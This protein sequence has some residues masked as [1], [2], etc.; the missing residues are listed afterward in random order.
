VNAH[1]QTIGL[2]MIVKNEA[3]VIRRCID[4]LRG[5]IDR[6]VIAD[7]GSTDGTQEI[8]REALA[9]IPGSLIE[10]PW[11]DFSHNR[12]EVLEH[13]R[14]EH[15]TDYTLLMDADDTLVVGDDFAGRRLEADAYDI[16]LLMGATAYHRQVLV[17]SALP[18]RYRG[19]LH[20][21]IHCPDAR[22]RATLPGES[23]RVRVMHEGARSR[24][25]M[26]YRRDALVLERALIDEPDNARHVFYLAQSYRDAGDPEL[27]LRYYR[28]RAAMGDW[29]DE[30][31]YALYQVAAMLER[32]EKPWP[33]VLAAYLAA[34]EFDRGRAEPLYWIGRHYQAAREF[35]T[36]QLFFARGLRVPPPGSDR[37]FV[38]RAIHDYLL[39]LEYAVMCY[40]TGDHAEAIAVNDQLLRGGTLPEG[41]V[42]RV[43]QNR[44]FSVEAL[45]PPAPTDSLAPAWT[46][47]PDARLAV[48]DAR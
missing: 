29:R 33:E 28:R 19:V 35:H 14:K 4:S 45:G 38:D 26:T 39:R 34:F 5:S 44:R 3:H 24:D 46:S 36:A 40:Y 9:G 18:W 17:R 16:E 30:A 8:I 48:A 27:A 10:R 7:T 15:P 21:Y 31:W 13:A 23:L 43:T 32:L 42:D 25:P 41:L 2:N 1:G 6:W 47:I 12:N 22:V 11:V 20:E 37:L